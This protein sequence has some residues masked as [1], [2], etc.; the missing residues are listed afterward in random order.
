MRSWNA[1]KAQILPTLKSTVERY[2]EYEL[3]LAGH[4][5][6]GA[7]AGLA[8]LDF[9]ASGWDLKVTTFGEPCFGNSGLAEFVDKSFASNNTVG[10]Y[11]RVTHVND[12][13]PFLPPKEWSWKQHAGEIYISKRGLPPSVADLHL[14][15]GSEDADCLDGADHLATDVGKL[16]T[17]VVQNPETASELVLDASLGIPTR[18]QIWQLL[19]A[20]REY[21]WRLGLCFDPQ[22]RS[23]DETSGEE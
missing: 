20:H 22:W 9:R 18:W 6:G 1:T 15:E 16:A 12:P 10:N 8:A 11:R 4:S 3:V 14:C 19:F 5:L 17:L 2:P 21:F 7:V 13:V 23:Y